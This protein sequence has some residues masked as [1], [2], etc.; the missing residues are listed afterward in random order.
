MSLPLLRY[1]KLQPIDP[2]DDGSMSALDVYD[3][4]EEIDLSQDEDGEA[5]L[6]EWDEI[7]TTLHE[8][9]NKDNE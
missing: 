6:K 3:E 7:S 5:L 4:D 2:Q 1:L 9:E 8:D